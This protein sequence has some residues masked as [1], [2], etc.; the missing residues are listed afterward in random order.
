MPAYIEYELDDSTSI[1]IEAPEDVGAGV[2]KVARG[3]SVVIKAKKKF[4]DAL[5]EINTQSRMLLKEIESL[6]VNEAEI[7]FGI[8][9]AGEVGNLVV[10]KLGFG[11][12]YE[13]TLKWKKAST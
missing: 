13:V 3:E 1:L 6:Q 12:N 9:T 10:G 8:T 4:S 2:V 7:K 5:K 11:V